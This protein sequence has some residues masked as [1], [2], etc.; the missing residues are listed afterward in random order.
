MKKYLLYAWVAVIFGS[1]S[2][3]GLDTVP[4]DVDAA[5]VNIVNDENFV[6]VSQA[7]EVAGLFMNANGNEGNVTTRNGSVAADK[8]VKDIKAIYGEDKTPSMYVI[9][10][11]GGGFVIV[12]ATKNYYPIL[13][14][15]EINSMDVE[16]AV[17]T[18]FAIWADETKQNIAG[19][20][21]WDKECQ[22]EFQR[23]WAAYEKP[24]TEIAPIGA[25]DD[26][27]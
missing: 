20:D 15:S 7:S 21:S 22:T 19:S 12:S 17:K 4:M 11:E 26:H 14:Y 8:V 16:E 25:T 1:C 3:S 6:P 13:A 27:Y 10:Y 5:C 18:G 24:K 9:N 23:M 2:E